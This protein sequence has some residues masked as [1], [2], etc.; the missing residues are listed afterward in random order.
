MD[1][2]QLANLSPPDAVVALRSYVRRFGAL[3]RPGEL[4]G[5]LPL[6]AV[7]QPGWSVQSL[8][9][10]AAHYVAVLEVGLGGRLDATN[11]SEPVASAVTT[12]GF[13][14]EEFLGT[15]LE[16]IAREKAGEDAVGQIAGA[17]PGLGQFI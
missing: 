16:A 5:D 12:I 3:V 11:V 13:D 15:T 7:V 10:A 14:H 4:A 2:H 1:R 9:A 17:I 6:D 8:L